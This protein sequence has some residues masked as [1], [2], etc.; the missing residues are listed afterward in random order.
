LGNAV[1]SELAGA[2]VLVLDDLP[3]DARDPGRVLRGL[4]WAATIHGS[5]D[6]W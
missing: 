4:R 6:G 1:T 5:L 2:A 3:L